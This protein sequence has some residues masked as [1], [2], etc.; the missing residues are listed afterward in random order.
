MCKE[1]GLS[2]DLRRGESSAICSQ[3]TLSCNMDMEGKQRL[4]QCDV[5]ER[6]LSDNSLLSILR[7][8]QERRVEYSHTRATNGGTMWAQCLSRRLQP[9][10]PTMGCTREI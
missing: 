1:W 9:T 10:P 8:I 7:E 6:A 2:Y 5:W 4:V 3:A